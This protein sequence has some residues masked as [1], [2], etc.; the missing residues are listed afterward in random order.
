[1]TSGS[2]FYHF[3]TKEDLLAWVIREGLTLG[4]DIAERALLSAH[5]PIAQYHALDLPFPASNNVG[6]A[7]RASASAAACGRA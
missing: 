5:T 7:L 6:D 2:I 4:H 3:P 1:M